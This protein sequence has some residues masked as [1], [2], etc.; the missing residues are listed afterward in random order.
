MDIKRIYID[1]DGVLADWWGGMLEVIKDKKPTAHDLMVHG[2][3]AEEFLTDGD[4]HRM[5]EIT[6]PEWWI[7][8]EKLPWCNEIYDTC[9]N[10]GL[11]VYILTSPPKLHP[12]R[13]WSLQGKTE[14]V[15]RNLSE[16][17]ETIFTNSKGLLATNECLMID[18]LPHNTEPFQNH[19][20]F[21]Q[22]WNCTTEDELN[23][24]ASSR[25][26]AIMMLK[27]FLEDPESW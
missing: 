27:Q 10:S 15:R 2:A 7:N 21:P 11:P 12:Y 1:L 14:W 8:L 19:I 20:L 6:R 17:Q 9:I 18:D 25:Q 24:L 13:S 16:K 22:P 26:S 4:K 23:F 3:R 5:W